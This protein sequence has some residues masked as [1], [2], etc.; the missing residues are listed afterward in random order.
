[1]SIKEKRLISTAP[2]GHSADQLC[3][4]LVRLAL[5]SLQKHLVN[6]AA[7]L[8]PMQTFFVQSFSKTLRVMDVRAKNRGRP[9]KKVRVFLRPQ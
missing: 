4:L 6:I 5:P 7:A 3:G 1:M 2:S 8:P 9:H